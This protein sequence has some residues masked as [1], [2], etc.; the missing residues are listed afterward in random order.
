MFCS[1]LHVSLPLIV[2]C[3]TPA[4]NRRPIVFVNVQLEHSPSVG[5]LSNICEDVMLFQPFESG[6]RI[7]S[8]LLSV[9]TQ[10]NKHIPGEYI[11]GRIVR[12]ELE[13]MGPG[14]GHMH[15][16]KP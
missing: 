10:N 14:P 7:E 2:L 9:A 4:R 13:N 15:G 11:A 1:N 6:S 5:V 3:W 8:G 16:R 12:A